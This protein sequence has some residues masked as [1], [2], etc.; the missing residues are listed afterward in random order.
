MSSRFEQP[1]SA[2]LVSIKLS[3]FVIIGLLMPSKNLDSTQC[4]V[5]IRFECS[6]SILS[7]GYLTSRSDFQDGVADEM[8]AAS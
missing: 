6:T 7:L 1:L 3:V 8:G 2:H 5:V 4:T